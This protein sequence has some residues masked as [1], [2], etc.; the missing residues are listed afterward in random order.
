MNEESKNMLYTLAQRIALIAS[1]FAIILS[2]LMIAN[3]IQTK[4]GDPLNS[5]ALTKLVGQLKENPGDQALKEQIRELDLLARKAFFT[6]RW[7]L[8]AAMY[9]L[10]ACLVLIFASLKA[11][12]N[13]RPEP[14]QPPTGEHASWWQLQSGLRK[15]T[16]IAA[17]AL[18]GIG[19][20]LSVISNVLWE[21]PAPEPVAANVP[22]VAT[23]EQNWPNFR[24]P[25]AN[26]HAHFT[27]VPTEWNGADGTNIKWKAEIPLP[28]FN[29]P[30]VWGDRIFLSGA[31]KTKQMVCCYDL[32]T[33]SLIWEKE[34]ASM[35][36]ADK[37]PTADDYTGYAAPSMATDGSHV[38]VIYATGDIAGLDLDGNQ[39]WAMNLGVPDNHY[40][41][42][43]SLICY[44]HLLIVQF[45][46]Y[47]NPRLLGLNGATGQTVWEQKRNQISWS[48][49]I[50][51]ITGKRM[52]LILTNSSSVTSF[53]PLTGK[54]LWNNDCLSGEVG[55]SAA[56]ADGYV[57]AAN[58]YAIGV[59]IKIPA[60]SGDEATIAWEYDDNLPNASSPLATDK[61][62]FLATGDGYVSCL[63]AKTGELFWEHEFDHGMYASAV[64]V[65]EL[66]YLMD[67]KG[68][69]HIFKADDEFELVSEPALGEKSS[70]T[71]AIVDGKIVVR[72]EKNLYCISVTGNR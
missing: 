36:S 12:Q 20:V 46:D 15:Y 39:L 67:L 34:I 19:L 21:R 17:S 7:Q 22:D 29:S 26:G 8:R 49:P 50:C 32:N 71:A 6:R 56:Y 1:I 4:A 66:V 44:Q 37:E 10:L 72:G 14:A 33:G 61:Y 70:C 48:S 57:Y 59:A 41:H 52:E 24:G 55:A 31:D 9:A 16:I 25:W 28:G 60:P 13:L 30:I 42:S 65:G 11:M 53:D 68:V 27:N 38:F 51:V 18:M 35:K 47:G 64:L 43:S 5:P 2:I 58:E 63:N 69:M 23:I 54:L 3:F 45:D 40:G 62:L